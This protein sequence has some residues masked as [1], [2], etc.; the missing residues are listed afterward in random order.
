MHR[1]LLLLFSL[2]VSFLWAQ[3]ESEV[4]LIEE[5]YL[6][7]LPEEAKLMELEL[8]RSITEGESKAA[9]YRACKDSTLKRGGNCFKVLFYQDEDEFRPRFKNA[10]HSRVRGFIYRL[11]PQEFSKA[12]E[13]LDSLK[14]QSRREWRETFLWLERESDK[15]IYQTGF[16]LQY[17]GESKLSTLPKISFLRLHN[18]KALKP[19]Y[20]VEAGGYPLLVTV[21]YSVAAVSGLEWSFLNLETSFSFFQS[22][23]TNDGNGLVG[24]FSETAFNLKLGFR[25][26]RM[27]L[28]LG[29]TFVLNQVGPAGVAFPPLFDIGRYQGQIFGLELE[30]L[31]F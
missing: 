13:D 6:L 15:I 24:P 18:S 4:L 20:G 22:R 26:A 9:I 12:A 31:A 5:Q 28:K 11:N 29:S 25:I 16:I 7:R 2:S 1:H 17:G 14:A 10:G 19:Y 21:A 23:G 8:P 27:R 30:Y 3:D